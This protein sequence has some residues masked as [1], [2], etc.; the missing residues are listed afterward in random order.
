MNYS[1]VYSSMTGNTHM[2]ADLVRETLPEADCVYF[3]VPAEEALAAD[4]LY[5]GFWTD[6]GSCDEAA[7][8]FLKT[9]KNREVFLF[10]TAGFGGSPDYFEKIIASVKAQ[11]DS[12]VTVVGSYMCQG[13]MPQS[14]RDRYESMRNSPK[15]IPNLDMLIENF[16]RALSHPDAKDLQDLEQALKAL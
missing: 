14:V 15:P 2:L 5:V 12:S 9:L 3:G 11:L 7:A 1:I 8:E 16:D 10:G 6:K 4:R 13:K